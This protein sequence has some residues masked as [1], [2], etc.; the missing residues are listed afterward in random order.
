MSSGIQKIRHIALNGPTKENRG[1][2]NRLRRRKHVRRRNWLRAGFRGSL[3]LKAGALPDQARRRGVHPRWSLGP[4]DFVGKCTSRC[5][6]SD[7][8]NRHQGNKHSIDRLRSKHSPPKRL[9]LTVPT[10][11]TQINRSAVDKLSKSLISDS[12]TFNN[13]WKRSRI[14][15]LRGR[16][17]RNANVK[18]I[19]FFVLRLITEAAL[20]TTDRE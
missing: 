19:N 12:Q 20:M 9:T 18:P 1:R 16:N 13:P 10:D 11:T 5:P 7:N 17:I 4:V 2:R 3:Q 6:S 15:V 14:L 8:Q